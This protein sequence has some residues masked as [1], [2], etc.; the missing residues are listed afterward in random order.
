MQDVRSR[1]TTTATM[2]KPFEVTGPDGAP[3]LVQQD[4]QG[5]ISPVQGYGPK[6]GASKPL[7]DSQAKALG[8]GARMQ[9]ADKALQGLEQ[10]GVTQPS[11]ARQI[12]GDTPF[13]GAAANAMSSPDQQTVE[14]VQRDFANAILRRESGA[15]ISASE[16]DNAKRQYFAQPGDSKEVRAVKAKNRDLA[17][18][19]VLAEVPVGQ[20]NALGTAPATGGRPSLDS[21]GKP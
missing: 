13:I 9:E 1:E 16:F 4:K 14:Q 18:R 7:T 12:T 21:F 6:T 10:K 8:F 19:G 3:M 17:T 20:R 11:I 15:A 5:N 2:T